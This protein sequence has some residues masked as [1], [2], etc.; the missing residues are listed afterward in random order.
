ML[1][2]LVRSRQ[3]LQCVRCISYTSKLVFNAINTKRQIPA[4][5]F[6][7]KAVLVVNTASL[8]GLTPQL[9][10]LEIVHKRFKVYCSDT[11]YLDA[12]NV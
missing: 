8:C 7:N 6:H 9:K 2:Q 3:A 1:R 10:E 12:A 5:T 4:S 11:L